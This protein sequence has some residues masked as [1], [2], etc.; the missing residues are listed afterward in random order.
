MRSPI[1]PSEKEFQQAVLELAAM[2][3]WRAYH[4]YDSRKSASGFPDLVLVHPLQRRVIFAELK[5][6]AGSVSVAQKDWMLDLLR[7]GADARLWRPSDWDIEI[8]P[9]LRGEPHGTEE[10]T[11]GCPSPPSSLSSVPEAGGVA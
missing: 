2:Y 7:A 5:T 9:A 1:E 6:N 4:T 10:R 8:E 3:G 11:S